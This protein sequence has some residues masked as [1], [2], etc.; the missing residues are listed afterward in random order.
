MS[1]PV[2]GETIAVITSYPELV[3]AF[4]AIKARL[5][6]SNKWCDET[7]DFADGVTDKLLG[8]SSTKSI[9]PLAFSMFC[10]M[11][12]V[13]F[14]MEID[15]EAVRKMEAYWESRE[16]G[17]VSVQKTRIGKELLE[18]AKPIVLKA[19]AHQ[20]VAGRMQMLTGE[21]RSRIARKAAKSRWKNQRKKRSKPR[22]VASTDRSDTI[23]ECSHDAPIRT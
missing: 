2:A 16:A 19:F 23:V 1:T 6:L 4:R 17:K 15:L 13:K 11:F 22:C 14:R 12:A 10:Q 18:R 3:E 20:G 8:P 5:Q 7:C 21:Q 9:G